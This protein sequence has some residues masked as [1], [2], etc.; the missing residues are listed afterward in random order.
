MYI[1]EYGTSLSSVFRQ[2]LR[3]P[4]SSFHFPILA[5]FTFFLQPLPLAKVIEYFN[6]QSFGGYQEELE[7]NNYISACVSYRHP[8]LSH[9]PDLPWST[10]LCFS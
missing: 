6:I 9:R 4:F 1:I 7:G 10:F 3:K 2:L 8:L 5:Y